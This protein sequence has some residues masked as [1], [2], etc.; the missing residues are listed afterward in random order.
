MRR[1]LLD[2]AVTLDGYIEGENGEV[3]WCI[4]EPEMNFADFLR[5]IDTIF[6]GRKS[7]NCGANIPPE[8]MQTKKK[9]NYGK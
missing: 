6:Y 5:Q 8:K 1:I 7:L 9:K 3:D 4:M 2:L